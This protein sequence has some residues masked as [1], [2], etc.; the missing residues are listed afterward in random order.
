ML[1]SLWVVFSQ[2]GF[3]YKTLLSI[4]QVLLF[5]AK[6]IQKNNA[7]NINISKYTF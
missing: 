3:S 1:A 5:C 2:Y 6:G 4:T 7:G